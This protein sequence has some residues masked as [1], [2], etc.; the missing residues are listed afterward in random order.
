[1]NSDLNNALEV[2][3]LLDEEK[4]FWLNEQRELDLAIAEL[5][6]DD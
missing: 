2:L 6:L 1:M 4:E 3:D 5:D